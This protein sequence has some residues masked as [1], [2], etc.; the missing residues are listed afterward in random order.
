VRVDVTLFATLGRYAPSGSR[1]STPFPLDLPDGTTVGALVAALGIPTDLTFL[2]LVN[3]DD[4]PLER[5][6]VAGDA[7]ALFPPLAGG[8]R[9]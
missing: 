7:V 2:A 3:G 5:S 8:A 9:R 6:L 4:S 1:T